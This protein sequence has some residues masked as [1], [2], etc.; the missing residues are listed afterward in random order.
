MGQLCLGRPIALQG[1]APT[2][3][4]ERAVVDGAQPWTP[5]AIE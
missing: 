2:H 5:M 4:V 3:V 1:S